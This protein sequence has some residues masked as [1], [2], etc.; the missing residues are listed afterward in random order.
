MCEYNESYYA[1]A[2]CQRKVYHV[3]IRCFSL[4]C[5]LTLRVGLASLSLQGHQA[6]YRT[7]ELLS[8]CLKLAPDT[9]IKGQVWQ[10]TSCDPIEFCRYWHHETAP[11]VKA[12]SGIVKFRSFA[13]MMHFTGISS[14][15]TVIRRHTYTARWLCHTWVLFRFI[16]A[17]CKTPEFCMS[18]EGSLGKS[19]L[20]TPWFSDRFLRRV[21]RLTASWKSL[22]EI[23]GTP[24]GKQ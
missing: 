22:M 20:N 9:G 21:A 14:G 23:L 11:H 5:V 6:E 3:C 19:Q 16:T 15:K 10:G 7:R 12:K 17:Q 4:L 24:F 2:R 13:R 1:L 18:R 8:E